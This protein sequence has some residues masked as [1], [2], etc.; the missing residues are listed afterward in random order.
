MDAATIAAVTIIAW[1]VWNPVAYLRGRPRESTAAHVRPATDR[2][3]EVYA[4][5]YK[6]P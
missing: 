1:T 5:N 6:G 4:N 3:I 2:V